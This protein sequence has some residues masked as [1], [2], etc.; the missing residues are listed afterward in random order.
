MGSQTTHPGQTAGES[1]KTYPPSTT[2][3]MVLSS[4]VIADKAVVIGDG[5]VRGV[6]GAANISIDGSSLIGPVYIK[7]ATHETTVLEFISAGSSAVNWLGIS[8]HITGNA[9]ILASRGTDAN[10]DLILTPKGTGILKT[11]NL[12]FDGNTL[13]STDTNGDINLTPDGTGQTVIGNAGDTQLGDATERNVYPH[14]AGKINL[15]TPTR[16]FNRVF[17]WF[18][19]LKE[20]SA[21]PTEPSEGQ[22][23]IWMS[24]GTGK[25]DDGDV[26]IASKAGG[27]TKYATLFDHS[28]GGAW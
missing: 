12:G 10:I 24:D 20:R 4:A 6:K 25:G 2:E 23:V 19:M 13:S 16:P 21:D 22:A 9:P 28:A 8:N 7:V 27:T 5:G 14:T 11:D 26:M 15:G 17:G 18:L 1:A 3:T